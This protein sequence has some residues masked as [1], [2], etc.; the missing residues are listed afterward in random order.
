MK[1]DFSQLSAPREPRGGRSELPLSIPQLRIAAQKAVNQPVSQVA[2]NDSTGA[3]GYPV[4]DGPF[5]PYCVPLSPDAV[6]AMQA[7]LVGLVDKLA[8][9]E[10]WHEGYREHVVERVSRQPLSTLRDDLAHFRARWQ[11]HEAVRLAAAVRD[12]N[13]KCATCQH[14]TFHESSVPIRCRHGRALGLQHHEWLD[15][16]DTPNPCREHTPKRGTPW[17]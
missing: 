11:A 7:E 2:A 9:T 17:A 4:A 13:R 12:A 15:A 1:L 3:S 14:R 6:A 5:T 10:G 8:D 16:P